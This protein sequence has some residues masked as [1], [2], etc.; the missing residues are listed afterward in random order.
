[1]NHTRWSSEYLLIKSIYSIGENKSELFAS[2]TDNLVKFSNNDLTGL[3]EIV[4][5]LE[6]F[7][8]ISIKC[9]A[10]AAVTVSLVVSSIAH[11]T[12]YLPNIQ[13]DL[14]LSR[15]RRTASKVC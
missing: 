10:E 15:T 9:Q 11:L 4:H 12:S 8:E 6:P 2:M 5:I 13:H 1:M 14:P 7:P 3:E